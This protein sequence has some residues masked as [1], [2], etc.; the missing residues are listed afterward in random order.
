MEMLGLFMLQEFPTAA[1][2]GIVQR[3][4][5]AAAVARQDSGGK[6]DD[7]HDSTSKSWR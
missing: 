5:A 4:A 7:K 3:Q 6:Q 1:G 2:S